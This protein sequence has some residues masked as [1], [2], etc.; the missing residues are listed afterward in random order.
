MVPWPAWSWPNGTGKPDLTVMQLSEDDRNYVQKRAAH[1][2]GRGWVFARIDEFLQ[3]PPGVFLLLGEP[4][5]GKTAIA[6]QLALAAAGQLAPAAAA[7]APYRAV[8]IA[9]AYFCRVG[10]VDLLD[11][12]KRLSGQLPGGPGVC[13]GAP[14][15]PGARDPCVG[16]TGADRGRFRRPGVWGLHRSGRLE[17]QAFVR[18]VTMPLKRVREEGERTRIVLLVDSLDESLAWKAAEMLPQLLGEVEHAHLL[19]TARPDHRAIGPLREHAQCVDLLADAPSGSDDA[20]IPAA[21][22]RTGGRASGDGGALAAVRRTG[23]RELLVRLPC[24]GRAPS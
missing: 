5:T 18:A 12:A 15:H 7:A 11:V 22:A 17:A 8:P 1:F 13:G 21:S 24:R 6:A 19:V 16:C 9:A 3:G 10:K 23:Q 4:G 2:T 14:G 20:G